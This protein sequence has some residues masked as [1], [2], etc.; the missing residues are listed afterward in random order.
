[1][2]D[3]LRLLGPTRTTSTPALAASASARSVGRWLAD[4]TLV[5]LHPGWVTVPELAEDWTVRAHAAA[6]YS[7]GPLSHLSALS[8]HGVIDFEATRLHVTV[9]P[10]SRIRTTRLLRVHR[11]VVPTAIVRA[12]GLP[13]TTLPR[14]LIDAWGLAHARAAIRGTVSV[15]RGALLGATRE[16]RVTADA[17]AAELSARPGLPGRA[18]LIE[19]LGL[20]DGGCQSEL[21]VFG[22]LHVLDVP[23][24]P[25]FTQQHRVV[26]PGG[27][28][29]LD[30]AWPEV[31]LAVEL[32]G[33]AFHG[34]RKAREADIARD[35]ALAARGW[36]VLRFSYHRL[37]NDPEGCRAQIAAV[38]RQR[39]GVGP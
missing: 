9:P 25:R 29:E 19:L 37:T 1:M 5:R 30:A 38:Y 8:A 4:G 34:S 13:V 33:A 23:G 6:G 3:L 39:L 18:G 16:K 28:V 20:V 22:V 32:D 17:V 26:L 2:H 35:V 24:L 7:G 10:G 36:L 31:R 11:T 14:S 21:E 27:P 12:R 15:V